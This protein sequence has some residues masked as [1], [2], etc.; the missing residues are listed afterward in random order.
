MKRLLTALVIIAL[1]AAITWAAVQ[2]PGDMPAAEPQHD[3]FMRTV[4]YGSLSGSC[5]VNGPTQYDRDFYSAE[6]ATLLF[7]FD[8]CDL[9]AL[10]RIESGLDPLAESPADAKGMCQLLE[11][12]F[13]EVRPGGDIWN[14]ADNAHAASAEMARNLG[15]WSWQRTPDQREELGIASYNCGRGC[16]AKAQ[17]KCDMAI[18]LAGMAECA[19]HESVEHVRRWKLALEGRW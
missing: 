15:F 7:G 18:T 9:K 1:V 2:S 5:A 16:M 3:P 13:A 19:P 10:C 12:T 17:I 4:L 6:K 8:W 14:P 11:K